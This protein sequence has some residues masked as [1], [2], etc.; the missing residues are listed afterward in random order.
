LK[1]PVQEGFIGFQ[2]AGTLWSENLTPPPPKPV[3][4]VV[5]PPSSTALEDA[6][7]HVVDDNVCDVKRP[8]S[9]GGGTLTELSKAIK[10]RLELYS[11]VHANRE[12]MLK[13]VKEFATN[14][15]LKKKLHT[16]SD[17]TDEEE[18][19]LTIVT[20]HSDVWG[21]VPPKEPKQVAKCA[22]CERKVSALH[23]ATHLD[24]CMNL[25]TARTAAA[26]NAAVSLVRGTSK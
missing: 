18:E 26:N 9:D 1:I 5:T 13:A 16:F 3:D 24:K 6:I 15:P 10:L 4:K 20:H 11:E 19:A 8:L 22:F 7:A 2:L 12:E 23:F 17:D 14:E 21:K 25:G